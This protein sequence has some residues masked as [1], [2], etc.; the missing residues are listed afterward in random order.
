MPTAEIVTAV[1]VRVRTNIMRRTAP[2]HQETLSRSRWSRHVAAGAATSRC[3]KIHGHSLRWRWLSLALLALCSCADARSAA[4]GLAARSAYIVTGV[5]HK[6]AAGALTSYLKTQGHGFSDPTVPT[7]KVPEPEC[8]IAG[9]GANGVGFVATMTPL[10]A[11]Y[12]AAALSQQLDPGD[13]WRPNGEVHPDV[14]GTYFLTPA[15]CDQ[16][17]PGG[18]YSRFDWARDRINATRD[19]A[20]LGCCDDS[21]AKVTG[22]SNRR[23]YIID[24]PINASHGLNLTRQIQ[25]TPGCRE[26]R[27][28]AHTGAPHGEDVAQVAAGA[29]V[30]VVPDLPFTAV[31]VGDGAPSLASTICAAKWLRRDV[32]KPG[33]DDMLAVVNFTLGFTICSAGEMHE[34]CA[35]PDLYQLLSDEA[36][37]LTKHSLVVAAAGNDLSFNG[38]AP[39]CD[40]APIAQAQLRVGALTPADG[41]HSMSYTSATPDK[42]SPC[43]NIFAPG[44]F[45]SVGGGRTENG[46]SVA[47]PLVSAIAMACIPDTTPLDPNA[48]ALAIIERGDPL[49]QLGGRV[50]AVC[51]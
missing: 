36:T 15:P 29:S 24:G 4:P 45:V 17:D 49:P 6:E 34:H 5:L 48:L 46:T 43:V 35:S 13:D 33:S 42:I 25:C 51:R 20:S 18:S 19:C 12:L 21:L 22:D 14:V 30:G 28:S 9:P 44:E 32:T 50:L 31:D 1:S 39:S 2:S 27:G 40:W 26:L 7:V 41:V 8:E 38:P 47:A 10:E 11:I 37:A 3:P 16:K 23:L